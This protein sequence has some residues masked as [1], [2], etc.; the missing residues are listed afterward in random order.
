VNVP[1]PPPRD[2]R[3]RRH[4][5]AT[6]RL[7][8]RL[9]GDGDSWTPTQIRRL[10]ADQGIDVALVTVRCWVVPGFA[11]EHRHQNA[12]GYRRRNH[13]DA[14]EPAQPKAEAEAEA[15]PAIDGEAVGPM[16]ETQADERMLLLRDRGLTYSA[17]SAVMA[18][19]HDYIV[20]EHQARYRLLRLGVPKMEAKSQAMRRQWA[21]T[22]AAA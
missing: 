16:T 11:E 21:E 6:V 15:C 5:M 1:P 7:A 20:A 2:R 22:K 10:L 14:T 19:Y 13:R 4:T 8:R 12:E 9:Y 3:Q 17:I 18:L